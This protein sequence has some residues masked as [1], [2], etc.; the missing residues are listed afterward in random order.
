MLRL[1][2]LVF[3]CASLDDG[4]AWMEA[5]LGQ[6][7]QGGGAHP[8]MGTCNALWRLGDAYLEMLA[9]DPE[10]PPP[11]RPRMFGLDLD[12]VRARLADG[13]FLLAWV[14]ASDDLDAAL[15]A[16]PF[17]IG[18][19][20]ALSR[21]DHL[22]RLTVS[23]DGRA[24]LGGLGPALIEW[25]QDAPHPVSRMRDMGLRLTRFW[26]ATPEPETLRAALAA[27]GAADLIEVTTGEGR[28]RL[29]CVIEGPGGPFVFD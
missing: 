12:D 1:D 5:R 9:V 7:A 19:P 21:G 14:A 15:A 4:R 27:V 25:P 28:P 22:W 29:G 24:P 13:P 2:H 10:A 20:V 3:A 16:A 17:P 23:A 11:G 8:A 6:P 18:A 26:C